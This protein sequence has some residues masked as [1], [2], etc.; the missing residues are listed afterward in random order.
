M[1]EVNGAEDLHFRHVSKL[2][3]ICEAF[4]TAHT[5]LLKLQL[6]R[7]FLKRETSTEGVANGEMGNLPSSSLLAALL[8]TEVLSVERMQRR[9]RCHRYPHRS[10]TEYSW[11][12]EGAVTDDVGEDGAGVISNDNCIFVDGDSDAVAC[13]SGG[14]GSDSEEE[15]DRGDGLY[16]EFSISVPI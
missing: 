7:K 2:A 4:A 14:D 9:V 10:T 12:G 16:C 5:V 6:Q 13:E 8:N 11:G 1:I 3:D 15:D